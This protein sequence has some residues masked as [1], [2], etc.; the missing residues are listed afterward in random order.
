MS[1]QYPEQKPEREPETRPKYVPLDPSILPEGMLESIMEVV[2][3]EANHAM[4]GR[5]EGMLAHADT[6]EEE[7]AAAKLAANFVSALTTSELR[8]V[9]A[10]TLAQSAQRHRQIDREERE[11]ESAAAAQL[12]PSPRIWNFLL[13][14]VRDPGT[15]VVMIF[16]G[17]ALGII[18]I[19]S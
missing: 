8:D 13:S 4:A 12:K 1:D 17:I 6:P 18:W 15:W 10:Y 3:A 5:V 14:L 11:R 7:S 9:L 2:G 19:A 16:V